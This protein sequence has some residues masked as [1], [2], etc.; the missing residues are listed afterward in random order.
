MV[1]TKPT[2]RGVWPQ[3]PSFC[4]ILSDDE[5]G[6]FVSRGQIASA[7]MNIQP[8]NSGHVLIVPNIPRPTMADVTRAE[9]ADMMRLALA[10][11]RALRSRDLPCVNLFWADGEAASQRPSTRTF[12][13]FRGG[14][15]M[16]SSSD[17][18]TTRPILRGRT[19]TPW[20]VSSAGSCKEKAPGQTQGFL[21][22]S[23]CPE[24][25]GYRRFLRPER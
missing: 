21:T 15:T 8:V 14:T 3:I 1:S 10:L 13:C 16:A 6:S 12:T 24:A 5:T 22:T 2:R 9:A 23:G 25:G 4:R 19:S 20:R 7:Y 17:P 18:T 11:N